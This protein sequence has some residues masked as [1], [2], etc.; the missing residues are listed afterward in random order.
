M[1]K[2][3]KPIKAVSSKS[4]STPKPKLKPK[5][6]AIAKPPTKPQ[7]KTAS[8]VPIQSITKPSPLAGTNSKPQP[9]AIT[10]EMIAFRA[11]EIWQRKSILQQ[12]NS[13]Y[14]NWIDAETELRIRK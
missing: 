1:P 7:K 4:K 5:S 12:S 2:K 14:Q 11:Y 8:A 13:E 9:P 3:K 6:K 10:H